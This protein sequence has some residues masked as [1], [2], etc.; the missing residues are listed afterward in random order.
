MAVSEQRVLPADIVD[1]FSKVLGTT[2]GIWKIE[3]FAEV[4]GKLVCSA[5]IL[6]AERKK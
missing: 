2:R 3:C 6:C 4:N 1:I 5:N